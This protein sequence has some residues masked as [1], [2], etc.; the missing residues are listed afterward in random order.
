MGIPKDTATV[1]SILALILIIPFNFFTSWAYPK[2][3]NWWAARSRK[4]LIKRIDKLKTSLSEM[5]EGWSLSI[6]HEWVLICA[7]RL[8]SL[9]Y[10]GVNLIAFLV[11]LVLIPTTR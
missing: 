6:T 5:A 8:G 9:V 3:Q 10:W 11:I 1:L 7:E 4:S 2:L